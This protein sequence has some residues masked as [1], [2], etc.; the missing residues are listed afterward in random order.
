MRI[1]IDNMD[2]QDCVF[3]NTTKRNIIYTKDGIFCNHKNKLTYIHVMN[4][5][6]ETVV[7]NGHTFI[8]DFSKE[9]YKGSINHIP[10]EHL[11][12]EETYDKKHIGFD[13]FYIRHSYFD[14]VAHYF[15]VERLEDY[16]YNIMYSFLSS[17]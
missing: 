14:Q 10:Y 8:L 4:D 2:I 5:T 6:Q 11:Y 3:D 7:N 17:K 15:E 16:M 9:I 1:Y 12:C 13:I